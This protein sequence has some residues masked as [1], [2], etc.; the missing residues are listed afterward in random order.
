MKK[1]CKLLVLLSMMFLLCACGSSKDGESDDVM[2]E[3]TVDSTEEQ[4]E[5]SQEQ[6]MQEDPATV[7]ETPTETP[8]EPIATA[9]PEKTP[10]APSETDSNFV[11]DVSAIAT[12]EEL[13][14][15]ITEHIEGIIASLYSDWEALSQ[16]IDSY[17]KYCKNQS[18]VSDFYEKV[19]DETEQMCI[20]IY[21]YS[22]VYAR[23]ILDS[24]MSDEDKYDCIEGINKF[25]Y[26]D[27]CELINDEIYEDLLGDMHDYYYGMSGGNNC[28]SNGAYPQVA[29]RF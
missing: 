18:V 19:M 3:S 23:M 29:S 26:D 9:A 20:I 16:E 14:T 10:Q 21:E 22:A 2:S 5:T 12:I 7:P 28:S 25:I 17:E 8:E 1:L 24:D 13:E 11:V 6:E 4:A 15:H 27:I